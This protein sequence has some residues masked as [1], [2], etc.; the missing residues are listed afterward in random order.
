[1]TLH[2]WSDLH[3]LIAFTVFALSATVLAWW[4]GFVAQRNAHPQAHLVRLAGWAW[5]FV[6]V[7]VLWLWRDLSFVLAC[8]WALIT[9]AAYVKPRRA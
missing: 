8:A 1:V 6:G 2:W 3:P 7:P 5:L 4:P 9:V